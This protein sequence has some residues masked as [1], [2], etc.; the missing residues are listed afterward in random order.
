MGVLANRQTFSFLFRL[1]KPVEHFLE[2]E[3]NRFFLRFQG[4]KNLMVSG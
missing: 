2:A 4:S 3:K 1:N